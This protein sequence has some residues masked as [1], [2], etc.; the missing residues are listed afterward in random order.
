MARDYRLQYLPGVEDEKGCAGIGQ[1]TK[2]GYD[3]E[4]AN[5]QHLRDAYVTRAG[6]LPEV[7][8][9]TA[10]SRAGC[11]CVQWR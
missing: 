7:R 1:L 10:A 9:D 8:R 5:G 11:V 3:Q 4:V 6:L 2:R